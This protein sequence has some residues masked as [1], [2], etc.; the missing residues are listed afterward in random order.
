MPRKPPPDFDF[1][2]HVDES[3]LSTPMDETVT[4]N[5]DIEV[6]DKEEPSLHEENLVHEEKKEHVQE[7][8]QHHEPPHTAEDSVTELSAVG[9][10][11]ILEAESIIDEEGAVEDHSSLGHP[12][13]DEDSTLEEECL[14]EPEDDEDTPQPTETVHDGNSATHSVSTSRRESTESN[15]KTSLRTEA[16][17]QAAARAVIA[18]IEEHDKNR[19]SL[20]ETDDADASVLSHTTEGTYGLDGTELSYDESPTQSRRESTRSAAASAPG[21]P[22]SE[23]GEAEPEGE[24]GDSSSHHE[25]DDDDVFSDQS[26]RS[27][28]GG[29][30]DGV[31]VDGDDDLSKSGETVQHREAS[32]RSPRVS[33]ISNLSQYENEDEDF[34][35]ATRSTPRPAF[36]TPSAVR[37]IQMS[38]P[39]PSVF[40][41]PRS[42]K[43]N[44]GALPTISRLGSP[45]ASAQYSPKGR[46]T[47]P[48]F[49]VRREAPLVLLHVTLLPLRWAWADV[50][51]RLE[52]SKDL[53]GF[54][55]SNNLKS[56]RDGWKQLQDRIGDTVLERGILLPHPQND[57]EVLEERL[58]EALDLPLRQRARILECGHY[59]GPSN[60][61]S[62]DDDE[63]ESEDDYYSSYREKARRSS[64]KSHWCTFCQANIK[65]EDLGPGKV[66]RIK[67]YA[68]NGLMKAGAWEACW[69]EME[70]VDIE[71][72][73]VL[74]SGVHVE[75]ERLANLQA[76][77]QERR[78]EAQRQED[79][80]LLARHE[81]SLTQQQALPPPM[82]PPL[83]TSPVEPPATTTT[84]GGGSVIK[85]TVEDQLREEHLRHEQLQRDAER[86]REI[87]GDTPLPAHTL[88]DETATS[89]RHEPHPDSYIPPLSPPSPSE[90]AYERR[91]SRR[92]TYQ[93]AS[94]PELLLESARVI[95]HDPKNVAIA[96]LAVFGLMMALRTAPAQEP[97]I[98]ATRETEMLRD[99]YARQEQLEQELAAKAAVS[100]VS[101]AAAAVEITT[102]A[103][104]ATT[105]IASVSS[106]V[107]VSVESA[108]Q[109]SSLVESPS[110]V[111]QSKVVRVVETVTE[112][113]KLTQQITESSTESAE[114]VTE[115]VRVTLTESVKAVQPTLPAEV[116]EEHDE[117]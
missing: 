27:S 79:V 17:I 30:Y 8:E 80:E 7:E 68:S 78:D 82:S 112:T 32:T 100:A 12:T 51:D 46:P 99:L 70:R 60:E 116:V 11:S 36:R 86:L 71:V 61:T 97:A 74:E 111:T 87:Y 88:G 113:V 47:P 92:R 16:L 55:P 90:Q 5:V 22:E 33:G 75:L 4:N 14:N 1:K 62:L 9:E 53:D 73:P 103:T 98:H 106:S 39:T 24:G 89:A 63:S 13:L 20:G 10:D 19:E 58:L 44:P 76:E 96:L 54:E 69:K 91:E 49:K 105:P 94:L 26:P 41:S 109:S 65:Y 66:F 95:F 102:T 3:C 108:P 43:R 38:S 72:E 114:T 29:S 56:L 107:Q 25:V 18:R 77:E 34:A 15:R 31:A 40:S 67:V 85:H 59:L 42:H 84:D 83:R 21:V 37:A 104:I 48:R 64:E 23:Q 101:A 81:A 115:T 110:V 117:L 57:Y 45:A 35:P 50:V 6:P 28:L 52:Q 2:I 93:S